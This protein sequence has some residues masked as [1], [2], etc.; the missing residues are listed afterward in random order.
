MNTINGNITQSLVTDGY[1][2]IKNVLLSDEIKGLKNTIKDHFLYGGV[3][4]PLGLTQPNAAVGVPDINWLFYHPKI[5]AVMRQLLGQEEIMFTSHCDLHCRTLS[6]WHKDD[7]MTVMEGGY[8]GFPAYDQEDCKVYKVAVYLQDHNHNKAGL[9]V[10]KG[11]HKLPDI[12]QGEEVYLKTQAGD[13]VIFDVRLTHTGQRDVIPVDFLQKPNYLLKKGLKRIFKISPGKTD[14]YLK[15]IYD[16]LF[17]DRLSI[18]FTYGLPNEY[19]KNFAINNM[20]RQ[21]RQNKNS[22]LFLSIENRQKFLKN[23]ILLAEE[24][25]KQLK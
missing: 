21:L 4:T 7:G 22:N 17:G 2:I 1:V 18:F 5:L 8:F 20:K 15:N 9:T 16:T 25:F 6:G 24:Y 3:K 14:Q 13:V 12:N 19:T 23:N 10:R 11:S